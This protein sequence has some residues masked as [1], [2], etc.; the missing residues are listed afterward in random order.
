MTAGESV[1][2]PRDVEAR[3][4]SM[5]AKGTPADMVARRLSRPADQVRDVA[6]RHGGSDLG[7][8]CRAAE[9]LAVETAP[10]PDLVVRAASV[11][12]L[13]PLAAAAQR[14]LDDLHTAMEA[15]ESRQKAAAELAQLE[16]EISQRQKRADKLR[17]L[18]E[19]SSAQVRAWAASQGIELARAGRIPARVMDAWRKAHHAR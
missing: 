15:Q 19:P 14:A 16:L 4:V 8:L 6:A 12:E 17:A 5:L 9:R 7:A 11:P 13:A 10:A 2:L 18:L 1:A 3:I